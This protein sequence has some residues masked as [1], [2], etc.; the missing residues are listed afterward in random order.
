M[1][2]DI[3]F[4]RSKKLA[5]NRVQTVLLS[6]KK[7]EAKTLSSLGY[8]AT[9]YPGVY[10]AQC[11]IIKNVLLLSLNELS[12]EPHNLWI[13]CFASRKKVKKEA[14]QK[15]DKL[16]FVS[17]ANELQ[18]FIKGLMQLSFETLKGEKDMALEI[19]PEA[20]TKLGKEFGS[21]WLA[22]LTVDEVLDRFEAKELAS[23]L[24]PAERL[25]GLKPEEVLPHFKP[26]DRLAGLDPKFIEDY[27]KQLK[28]Q[29]H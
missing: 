8:Q 13:K 11:P 12:N 10:R 23:H 15:L 29:Q 25:A 1:G 9:E 6:A 24:K 14:F 3:F 18:W 17:I 27:L 4:K 16:G 28:R 21:L 5:A 22:N 26:V 7:P 2:Y 19:T 20:V